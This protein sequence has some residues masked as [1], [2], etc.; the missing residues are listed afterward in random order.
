VNQDRL[1]R[2]VDDRILAGVCGGLAD[3]LAIDP[4]VVRIVWVLLTFASGGLFLLVYIVMALVVPEEDHLGFVPPPPSAAGWSGYPTNAPSAAAPEPG[5]A[6]QGGAAGIGTDSGTAPGSGPSAAPGWTPPVPPGGAWVTPAA[7]AQ[8]RAE[9]RAARAAQRG[10]RGP[11]QAS[12]VL[13]VILILLGAW[14]LLEQYV[15]A[16]D[17]D[18]FWPF[19]LL[20][21]GVLLLAFAF[22]GWPGGK[23]ETKP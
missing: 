19:A 22:G 20:F 7:Q 16:F 14:F 9:R 2:S 5:I 18:R 3:R 8:W 13:G 4:S 10:N 17:P 23:R 11:G 12:L 6:P 15:P 21:L 1:Y